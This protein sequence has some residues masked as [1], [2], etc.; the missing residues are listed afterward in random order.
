MQI[1][2]EQKRGAQYYLCAGYFDE[3]TVKRVSQ[4]SFQTNVYIPTFAFSALYIQNQC[5]A[6]V[7]HGT[8]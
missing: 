1:V 7:G 8:D 5:D 3:S 6:A 4:N 2:V